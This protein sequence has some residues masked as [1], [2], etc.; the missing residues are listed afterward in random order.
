MN[1]T[2]AII[3]GGAD[4]VWDDLGILEDEIL[5][6]PWRDLV[7]A[8]N[9]AGIH[10]RRTVHH[11]VTLHPEKFE[12]VLEP[13]N[14]GEWLARRMAL[15]HPGGMT[16]WSRRA[17]HIVDRK[18]EKWDNDGGSGL[19]A[20]AV[21]ERLGCGRVV[22][23]GMPM[24]KRPHYHDA[25]DGEPWQDVEKHWRGWMRQKHRIDGWVRSMSGRTRK[26]FGYPT[27]HWLGLNT[28]RSR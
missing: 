27:P 14:T 25:H 12:R 23:C 13:G 15:G 21:A 18:L 6:H 19:L 8:V 1:P 3:L 28:A 5:G 7:I 11:W 17:E 10:F 24:D 4:C 22:L 16:L 26:M 20:V 9:D 2:R